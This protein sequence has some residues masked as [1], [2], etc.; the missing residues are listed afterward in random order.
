MTQ[1]SRATLL[2]QGLEPHEIDG[3]SE[4]LTSELAK[5]E[6]TVQSSYQT[7]CDDM[8]GGRDAGKLSFGEFVNRGAGRLPEVIENPLVGWGDQVCCQVYTELVAMC[9]GMLPR[10]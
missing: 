4:H 5:M 6:E 8:L 3:A 1:L 2:Q 10:D 7:M 9:Q